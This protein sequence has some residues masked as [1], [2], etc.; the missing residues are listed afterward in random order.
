MSTFL[1]GLA[2]TIIIILMG[3]IVLG[4]SDILKHDSDERP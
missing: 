1:A 4:V 3:F 2:I